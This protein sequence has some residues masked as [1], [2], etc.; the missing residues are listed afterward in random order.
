MFDILDV[1]AAHHQLCILST[2]QV[3]ISMILPVRII[4]LLRSP[5]SLLSYLYTRQLEELTSFKKF[6][7]RELGKGITTMF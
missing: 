6:V 5:F 7:R 3:V 2:K 1:L 4:Q